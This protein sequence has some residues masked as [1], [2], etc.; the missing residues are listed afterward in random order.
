MSIFILISGFLHTQGYCKKP[1]IWIKRSKNF[2]LLEAWAKEAT[3]CGRKNTMEFYHPGSKVGQ[4]W[5]NAQSHIKVCHSLAVHCGISFACAG[6]CRQKR[7]QTAPLI[8]LLCSGSGIYTETPDWGRA[9]NEDVLKLVLQWPSTLKR[10][11]RY[12][13]SDLWRSTCLKERN[14]ANP[15]T[16]LETFE[17]RYLKGN[18]DRFN[19]SSLE[20]TY[21]DIRGVK[22][23]KHYYSQWCKETNF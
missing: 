10:R 16:R 21:Q 4:L 14:N 2:H 22:S 15:F 5:P 9:G 7:Q 23:A 17:K 3:L 1:W 12:K 13:R 11:L 6:G 20:W 19:F 8:G 18:G